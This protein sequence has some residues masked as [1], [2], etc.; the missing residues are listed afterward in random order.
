MRIHGIMEWDRDGSDLKAQ[1]SR[2]WEPSG[3]SFQPGWDHRSVEK[4]MEKKTGKN[5]EN[6]E[7]ER[8]RKF[9]Y[10]SPAADFSRPH[11]P[12]SGGV[13]GARGSH[14]IPALPSSL[15]TLEQPGTS[16]RREGSGTGGSGRKSK[17]IPWKFQSLER[18]LLP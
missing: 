1:N 8:G 9:P 10:K 4:T 13:P 18:F 11:H 15:P 12:R 17:P 16:S 3:I 6:W 5:M 14:G 2:N 7:K